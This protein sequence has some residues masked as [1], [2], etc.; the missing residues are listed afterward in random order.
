MNITLDRKKHNP[1]S[2]G[3]INEMS[4]E[5]NSVDRIIGIYRYFFSTQSGGRTDFNY[6]APP[7]PVTGRRRLN[8]SSQHL[9]NPYAATPV[10]D[11]RSLDGTTA[12]VHLS[13]ANVAGRRWT[14]AYK[15]E[16]LDSRVKPTHALATLLAGL[17]PKPSVLV[18][19]SA[20]G[21]Y[22]GRG[23]EL[24]TE[25]SLPGNGFLPQVCLAWE[26][27]TQPAIGRW[28]TGGASAFWRGALAR[29]G[30]PGEDAAHLPRRAGGPAR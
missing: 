11:P 8:A 16:I 1:A 26:K 25:A 30:R 17:R 14:S 4:A 27:A 13:G 24:L 29:W 2:R 3:E 19:A 10:S 6:F 5:P 15:R 18:C 23:D 12:A 7:A 28:D 20:I 9:W 22:G 21:I